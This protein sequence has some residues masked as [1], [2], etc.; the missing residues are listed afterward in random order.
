VKKLF[1]FFTVFY[2]LHRSNFVHYFFSLCFSVKKAFQKTNKIIL[3]NHV[4]LNK[5]SIFTGPS[6]QKKPFKNIHAKKI[7]SGSQKLTRIGKKTIFRFQSPF[8]AG[9]YQKNN[10]PSKTKRNLEQYV[11]KKEVRN[12]KCN[13]DIL[14]E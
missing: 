7:G 6:E 4:K 3:L 12:E 13:M 2:F 10:C 14:D 8:T 11:E 1:I 5:M 9:L